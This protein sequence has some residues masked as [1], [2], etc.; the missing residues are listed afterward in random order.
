M[1]AT[2]QRPEHAGRHPDAGCGDRRLDEV[3][4]VV[5]CKPRVD[6]PTRAIEYILDLSFGLGPGEGSCATM[7]LDTTSSI[8]VPRQTMRFQQQRE[9]V[10]EALPAA[11]ATRGVQ[12]PRDTVACMAGIPWG[13]GVYARTAAARVSQLASSSHPVCDDLVRRPRHRG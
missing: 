12:S 6:G 2:Q 7:R 11:E 10:V 1:Q 4:R 9:E 13:T 8:R 3:H 5:D